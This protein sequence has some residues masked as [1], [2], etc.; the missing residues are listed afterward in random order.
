MDNRYQNYIATSTDREAARM[1]AALCT[2]KDEAINRLKQ[3]LEG[4]LSRC[5]TCERLTD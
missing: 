2:I 3:E 4:A 5:Q 1:L